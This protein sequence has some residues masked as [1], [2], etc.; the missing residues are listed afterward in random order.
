MNEKIFLSCPHLRGNEEKYVSECIRTEWISSA[1]KYVDQ[2]ENNLAKYVGARSAAAC[3]NGT[4]ALHICLILAGVERDE[5]VI[6]P[7]LT[8]I[9]PVNTVRYVGAEPVFMDCDDYLNI[10]VDKLTEFLKTECKVTNKI[11]SNKR[12]GRRIRTIIPVHVF[13]SLC[14]MDELM[15]LAEKYNLCVIE[16]ATESLGSYMTTGKYKNQHSGTIG[17]FGCYSFNGNKIITTGGGGMI[18]ANDN[19]LVEKAKYLTTQAKNDP[20]HYI[21]DE[22]GYNYRMTSVQAAMGVA[23]MEQLPEFIERKEK[24]YNRYK[25]LIKD[26]KGLRLL[27]VP[28]Y[29]KS[30]YWFYS[31]FIDKEKYGLGRD[32]LMMK[33]ENEG[34][35]TRPIWKLNN[36]Q[37]PYINNQ[38]YMIEKADYYFEH[39]LNIPC[40]VGLTDEELER[41][42]EALKDSAAE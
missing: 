9:S 24:N 39:I 34:I 26:I 7:A 41:V 10:D 40:S 33:L 17:H 11:L 13:G 1:G 28:D 14:A 37:K 25:E 42:V 3:M 31:L 20:L 22:V 19:S 15:A 30:N 27:D 35:Q 4:A 8:F 6:V 2:F 21:H 32:E 23:Q 36:R 16:D 18:V 38:A 5:E 12:T 29:C